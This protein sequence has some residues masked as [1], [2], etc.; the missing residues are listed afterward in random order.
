M[1]ES[2]AVHSLS[3]LQRD[4]DEDRPA[5]HSTNTTAVA[6]EIIQN[7]CELSSHLEKEK[8][9]NKERH[10]QFL[11][12]YYIANMAY[13]YSISDKKRHWVVKFTLM[14]SFRFTQKH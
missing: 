7:R 10:I 1:K 9:R 4:D 5:V 8:Q 3:C 14:N 11:A 13:K 2:K 12:L 6:H